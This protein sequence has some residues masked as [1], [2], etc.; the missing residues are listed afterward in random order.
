MGRLSRWLRANGASGAWPMADGGSR[1]W[2]TAHGVCLLLWLAA[3]PAS[4]E[5]HKLIVFANAEGATIHGKAYFLGGTPARGLAVTAFG[6]QGAELDQTTTDEKGEFTMEAQFGCDHRL[7]VETPDGHEAEFTLRAEQLPSD[8]PPPD[9]AAEPRPQD[10]HAHS[11]HDGHSHAGHS[12]PHGEHSHHPPSAE[13]ATSKNTGAGPSGELRALRADVAALQEQLTRYEN[14]TR[15][16][17]V[18]GGIGYILGLAGIAFYFL[19]TR[20]KAAAESQEP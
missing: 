20:R 1:T 17:D 5:A 8:L 18:L 9:E 6:P 16:R 2:R 10:E 13:P 19:G 14:R 11:S 4:A 3:L 15:L 7:V 12:H